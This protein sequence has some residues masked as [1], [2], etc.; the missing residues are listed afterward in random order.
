M[1]WLD[2]FLGTVGPD[3]TSGNLTRLIQSSRLARLVLTGAY[4]RFMDAY[5][6]VYDS[7]M[8]PHNK[9]EFPSTI[10]SRSV[11]DVQTLLAVD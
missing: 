11:N 5:K 8:D 3:D 7:V 2:I 9:Y 1:K 6:L 10:L 4:K